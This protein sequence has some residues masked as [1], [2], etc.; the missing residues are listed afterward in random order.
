MS[1]RLRPCHQDLPQPPPQLEPSL[2]EREVLVSDLSA[3]NKPDQGHLYVPVNQTSYV[4]F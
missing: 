3:G 1:L 2:R 4:K